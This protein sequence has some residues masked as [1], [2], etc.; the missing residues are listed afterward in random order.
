MIGPV[1]ALDVGER[2][3]GVAISDALGILATPVVTLKRRSL[4][5]DLAAIMQLARERGVTRIIVGHPV[6]MDGS[7]S[8]QARVSERFA[9]RLAEALGPDGPPV[10]LWDERL[11]TQIAEERL[12]A[13]GSSGRAGLDATAAAVILEEWLEARRGPALLPEPPEPDEE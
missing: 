2:R 4:A 10:E 1:M 12:R 6:H 13:V 7:V 9:Q 5:R 11:S 8:A 3:I